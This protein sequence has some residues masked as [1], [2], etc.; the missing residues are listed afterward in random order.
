MTWIGEIGPF[1]TTSRDF[2][3]V[4][5]KS[6]LFHP[7]LPKFYVNA[8]ESGKTLVYDSR[9]LAKIGTIT[10]ATG[11][12]FDAR[13][14]GG[15][16]GKPV[17]GVFT[18]KGRYLWITYYRLT[19]DPTGTKPSMFAQIDTATDIV[20]GV[21]ATGNVPKAIATNSAG[22]RLAVTLW[23][24]NA[25]S[26]YDVRDPL[27]VRPLG[28]VRVGASVV[29]RPGTNRDRTCGLCLR[30]TVF[31]PGTPYLVVGAMHGGGL[32]VIDTTS[33]S[34]VK[35][36][37]GTPATPRHLTI[38]GDHLYFSANVSGTVARIRLENLIAHV[39][40]GEALDIR[41]KRVGDG[42]RTLK[43]VAGKIYV[44]LN[45]SRKI[46]RM[47]LDFSNVEYTQAAPFP[48]GLDVKDDLLV[49]TSQ[50]Q[51]G[52][53]GHR[54][55]VYRISDTEPDVAENAASNHPAPSPA[56]HDA[57]VEPPTVAREPAGLTQAAKGAGRTPAGSVVASAAPLV[58]TA[59]RA[60]LETPRNEGNGVV[61]AAAANRPIFIHLESHASRAQA[62][63]SV[64]TLAAGP[65][66][67]LPYVI[68]EFHAPQSGQTWFRVIIDGYE[69]I[70]AAR[71]VCDRFHAAK[72][73]CLPM[74]R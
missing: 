72:H 1:S 21:H 46:A 12:Q 74:R 59:V 13:G 22:D 7:V 65:F 42:A 10:H 23:G 31:I 58:A 3:V 9:S 55:G 44:A 17:E 36:I 28:T 71:G 11:R 64:A 60:V 24:E 2:E 73:Y 52:A 68:S 14:S 34:V 54:V 45:G 6:V 25:V 16:L 66:K 61:Q 48:V 33:F 53:G 18:H 70:G 26:L 19:S 62:E 69:S 63:R 47:N 41:T 39:E 8:L 29:A 51:N 57:P 40:R 5:P 43:I 38:Y 50:G 67:G 27:S 30:G 4:S 56:R 32:A 37:T 15:T 49:V 35:T 20:V